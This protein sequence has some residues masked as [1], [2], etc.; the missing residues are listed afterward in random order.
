MILRALED[1][2]YPPSALE[3]E[4][5]ESVAM[6]DIALTINVMSALAA[7]GIRFSL[8]DFGTGYSS[9]YYLRKLPIEWLKIDQSFVREIGPGSTTENA[10]VKAIISMAKSLGL[11]TIAEGCETPH[12]YRYLREL[13]CDQIQG[14]L[15]SRPLPEP[16]FG[17]LLKRAPLPLPEV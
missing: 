6:R 9:F 11:G 1:M 14:F 7:E 17:A 3:L 16:D 10:I 12:H 5:T 8:D 4:I 13:G 15:F 2:D